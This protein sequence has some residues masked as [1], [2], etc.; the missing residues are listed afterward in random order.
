MTFLHIIWNS[1]DIISRKSMVFKTLSLAVC[2][3][4]LSCY[5]DLD[6]IRPPEIPPAPVKIVSIEPNIIVAGTQ[7][8]IVIERANDSVEVLGPIL[9]TENLYVD[10]WVHDSLSFMFP[11]IISFT[12]MYFEVHDP[13][14][15]SSFHLNID[16][17]PHPEICGDS[18]CVAWSNIDTVKLNYFSTGWIPSTSGDTI[19]LSWEELG[20]DFFYGKYLTFIDNGP[21]RLPTFVSFK[22]NDT[23]PGFEPRRI[24]KRGYI[25]ID[26]WDP[27]GIIRGVIFPLDSNQWGLAY[28]FY[29]LLQ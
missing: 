10:R 23:L 28:P 12:G 29:V 16:I 21:D 6:I 9:N 3:I 8:Q 26:Q 19:T 24:L 14:T 7:V 1:A 17:T 13:S 27:Q 20:P 5:K 4:T 25:K 15:D 2:F 11:Y 18:I 22:V